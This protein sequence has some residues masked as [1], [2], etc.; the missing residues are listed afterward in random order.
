MHTFQRIVRVSSLLS[1]LLAL[2]LLGL[3]TAADRGLE[4]GKP[5]DAGM[6]AGPLASSRTI[7]PSSVADSK[8]A[9]TSQTNECRVLGGN[10]AASYTNN[11]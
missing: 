10:E 3:A 4:P 11:S 2:A 7:S 8:S 1:A 5:S 6:V 9:W